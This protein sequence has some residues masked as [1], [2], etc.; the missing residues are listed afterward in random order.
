MHSTA[1]VY[2]GGYAG[3]PK[4]VVA[5]V[6][7]LARRLRFIEPNVDS[8]LRNPKTQLDRDG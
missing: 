1:H 6:F 8:I 4:S 3:I 7:E 2:S 5:P